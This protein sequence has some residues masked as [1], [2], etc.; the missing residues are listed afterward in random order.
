MLLKVLSYLTGPWLATGL[1]IGIALRLGIWSGIGFVF[2]GCI[3]RQ[4]V[5]EAI[6]FTI[7]PIMLHKCEF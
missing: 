5:F 7:V 2:G 6:R 4:Q 1:V 3:S